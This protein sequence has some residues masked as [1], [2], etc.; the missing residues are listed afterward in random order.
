[1]DD[2]L[3]PGDLYWRAVDPYWAEVSIYDGAAVLGCDLAQIPPGSANL[4]CAHWCQSEV[5]NGGFHQFF[6]NST[7]VLAPEAVAGFYAIGMPTCAWLIE[8]A[9]KFFGDP[10]PRERQSRI[11]VLKPYDIQ[12]PDQEDPF[13][14]LDDR[15]YEVV[16]SENGGFLSAADQ[17]AAGLTA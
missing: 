13:G 11:E 12:D 4:L 9:M 15:F 10:Y 6:Y 14:S 3:D 5:R 16:D 1:M 8:E 2:Q 7:G 17:Y